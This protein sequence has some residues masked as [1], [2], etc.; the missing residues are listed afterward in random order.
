[1]A[2][3]DVFADIDEMQ[4]PVVPAGLVLAAVMSTSSQAL[5]ATAIVFSQDIFGW[6]QAA[7]SRPHGHIR[8]NHTYVA[9]LASGQLMEIQEFAPQAYRV[10]GNG[11]V[12]AA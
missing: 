11:G 1:V 6:L 4:L 8:S 5:I 9:E 10:R 2:P 3:G 12:G 7:T